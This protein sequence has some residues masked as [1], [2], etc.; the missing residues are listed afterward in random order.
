M[1]ANVV[2]VGAISCCVGEILRSKVL[3]GGPL[4]R[5]E[6]SPGFTACALNSTGW[7]GC[8]HWSRPATAVFFSHADVHVGR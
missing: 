3:N 5:S 1:I 8:R 6:R 2:C 4:V 7:E